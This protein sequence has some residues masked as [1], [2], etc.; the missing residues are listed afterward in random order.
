MN[1]RKLP[2]NIQNQGV[3]I[4]LNGYFSNHKFGQFGRPRLH[5]KPSKPPLRANACSSNTDGTT[6]AVAS[7]PVTHRDKI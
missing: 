6:S 5:P 7:A 2:K 3:A 1:F 4:Y